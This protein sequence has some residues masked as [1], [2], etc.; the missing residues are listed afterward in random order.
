MPSEFRLSLIDAPKAM[1]PREIVSAVFLVGF[2]GDKILAVRNERGWDVPGGH[3]E[4]D[5]SLAE[6]LRREVREEAGATFVEA[7]PI[8]VLSKPEQA[9]LMLFFAA[10]GCILGRFEPKEDA[11][12]R[13]LLDRGQLLARYHGDRMLL[14][15]LI[16]SACQKLGRDPAEATA[17]QNG[18]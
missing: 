6:G 14:A 8:A 17:A 12:E 13:R 3:L 4:E 2:V 18:R 1:P 15:Q 5:E 7:I 10:D 9:K 11:F 16:A